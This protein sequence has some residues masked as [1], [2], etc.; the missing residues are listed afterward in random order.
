MIPLWNTLESQLVYILL[1]EPHVCLPETL[2][3]V[4][5]YGLCRSISRGQSPRLTSR[6]LCLPHGHLFPFHAETEETAV[7]R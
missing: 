4:G 3:L 5:Y 1:T 7:G 2:V 6:S